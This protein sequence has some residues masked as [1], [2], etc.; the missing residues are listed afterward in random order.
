MRF[1]RCN[2]AEW[3]HRKAA[4]VDFP[5]GWRDVQP[6]KYIAPLYGV[7]F[8]FTRE[9]KKRRF[10]ATHI[11]RKWTY[12]TLE[13]WFWT[14]CGQIVSIRVKTL[15]HTDLRR[16]GILK[17]KKSL[18]CVA[19]KRCCLSYLMSFLGIS[20]IY[21]V[22]YTSASSSKV[23]WGTED[24]NFLAS[25]KTSSCFCCSSAILAS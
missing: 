11:N 22:A 9:F 19:Q 12:C 7:T 2:I 14:K 23:A 24:L 10:W 20:N 17:E 15:S 6:I 1:Y 18:T 3:K 8:L 4:R 5:K 21:K 16:Q 13:P 25:R